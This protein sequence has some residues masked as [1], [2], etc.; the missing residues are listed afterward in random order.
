VYGCSIVRFK[1]TPN[2]CIADHWRKPK[3]PESRV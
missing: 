2:D 3:L 1:H